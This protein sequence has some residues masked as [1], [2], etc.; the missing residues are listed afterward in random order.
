MI[1]SVFGTL[2]IS[3]QI[4]ITGF[5]IAAQGIPLLLSYILMWLFQGA[6]EEI[7]FRGYMMPRVAS[8]YGLIPAIA[9]SSLLFCLFHGLN[10]GFSVLAFVNLVLI[11]V[12]YGLIAYYTDNIWIVCAAHTMWNFTQG[13]V[14][15]LEVSGN[16]GNVSFI[17]TELGDKANALITGGTFGPEGGLAVT[18]VTVIALVAVVIIFRNRKKKQ[19]K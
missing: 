2:V 8:R 11:S 3:G 18:I 7:M 6:C 12:L 10:P 15:G 5:G 9:V 19:R 4:R 14:F 1:A 13:N 16:T 17:H